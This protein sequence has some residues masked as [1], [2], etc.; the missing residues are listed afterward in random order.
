MTTIA[1]SIGI[2]RHSSPEIRDLAGARR[3]AMALH[4]LIRDSIPD[5][6]AQLLCDEQATASAIRNAI[7][8]SLGVAGEDDT[9]ILSFACHGSQDHRIIATD[10]RLD[11]LAGTSIPMAELAEAFRATNAGVVLC[12]LDCCFS[13]GAPARVLENTPSTRDPGNPLKALSGRGKVIFAAANVNEPA[14]EHP[15]ARHGLLT[16][17]II[18]VLIATDSPLGIGVAIDQILD[19]IRADA[20]QIGVVQTPYL[21]NSVEG[22]LTLPVFRRGRLYKDAFPEFAGVRISEN[23]HELAA[24]AVQEPV[25]EQWFQRYP[26]G[27]NNLQLKAVNDYRILDGN[28]LLVV[29][30][31]SA[32]KTFIGEM[33][34]AK[35][36]AENRRSV[37]LLPYKALVNEKY[38]QF[39]SIYE[40]K[41]GYRVIRCTGDFSDETRELINA[42]YEIALLTYEMFLSIIMQKPN[43]LNSVGLVVLDEAQFIT[44]PTRGIVVELLLTYLLT[45]KHERSVSPQLLALSAVIGDINDFDAWLGCERLVMTERPVPLVE[46]VL[47]RQGMFQFF[48]INGVERVEEFLPHGDIVQR[49]QKPS[50]QDVIVPLA[51]QLVG[52][53]E[54]IIVFRNNRGSAQGCAKYLANELGLPGENSLASALVTTDPSSATRTLQHCVANGTAFHTSNLRREERELIER[55]YRETSS[56]VRILAATTTVA[57]GINTPADTVIIAEQEF[58]GEDGRPF[59]V[60]EYKNM[61]G[62]AGRLGVRDRGR[63]VILAETSH[64]RAQLFQKYVRGTP[65]AIRSSFDPQHLDTWI[66]RLLVQFGDVPRNEVAHLLGSCYGGYLANRADPKWQTKTASDVEQLLLRMLDLQL[67]EEE[68]GTI[69]LTLLGRACGESILSFPSA[70]RLVEFI[71]RLNVGPLPAETLLVLLQGLS[72]SDRIY[73]PLSNAKGKEGRW[74]FDASSRF[75]GNAVDLLKSF[76]PDMNAYWARCKR[77]AILGDWILG[78]PI[79]QIEQKYSANAY[80]HVGYG[81]VRNIADATRFHMRS[82]RQIVSL[83]VSASVDFEEQVDNLLVQ[84]ELGIPREALA[85]AELPISLERSQYLLLLSAGVTTHAQLW[86]CDRESLKGIVGEAAAERLETIRPA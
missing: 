28:S 22:G 16:K 10:T 60:A 57:A 45:A 42:K 43:A 25:I 38:D 86:A 79:E 6:Q 36:V 83:L 69:H 75:D 61:A 82:A 80:S 54:K 1:I 12:I 56:N 2:N 23:M 65:E 76:A 71:R 66:L 40:D 81:D 64:Q 85:L 84:L 19:R 7:Q 31:T 50:A 73:T 39:C 74:A 51:K 30:P 8:S 72:E 37:F 32:G 53:G 59:T 68:L 13:G 48:D 4:C 44:D 20:G 33:A 21:V 5:V 15:S 47:D 55:S 52:Q 11:D 78:L 24:F 29:A 34:A 18:E 26:L 46:G 3:D 17:A 58:K 62:R 70:M 77:A 63:S 14:Y 27:L 49:T 35:A 9:V 41:L 67:V